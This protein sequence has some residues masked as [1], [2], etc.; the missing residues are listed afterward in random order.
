MDFSLDVILIVAL[1]W[2][3]G[4]VAILMLLSQVSELKYLALSLKILIE[5][6][7]AVDCALLFV[8][9]AGLLTMK[10]VWIDTAIVVSTLSI[11][12]FYIVPLRQAF[13]LEVLVIIYLIY[14]RGGF[15][16]KRLKYVIPIVL[17]TSSCVA[18]TTDAN[19]LLPSGKLV[20]H[21]DLTSDKGCF[22]AT[23]CLYN[24]QDIFPT[25]DFY[26][27][28]ISICCINRKFNS[29]MVNASTPI[30]E[31]QA[32]YWEPESYSGSVF[33]VGFGVVT[34]LIGEPTGI[35][36]VHQGTNY[37]CWSESVITPKYDEVFSSNFR[38]PEGMNFTYT[39]TA[40]LKLEDK[41]FGILW[42]DTLIFTS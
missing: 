4:F 26:Y 10:R 11:V 34:F 22:N 2:I 6:T 37:L 9:G 15:S 36:T 16:L 41:V 40:E 5:A 35:I 17:L 28:N 7:T 12:A 8:V 38:V 30:P 29:I 42:S 25:V 20:Q 18:F 1:H 24:G 3:C 19:A 14:K 27:L 39:L 33:S 32:T 23:I 31:A 13:P 21:C